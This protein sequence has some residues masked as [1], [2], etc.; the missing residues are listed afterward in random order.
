MVL[1]EIRRIARCMLLAGSLLALASPAFA[2]RDLKN[3]PDPDPEEER[4]TFIVAD[5]FEVNLYA[6][7]PLLAKPIQMNFDAQGRLWIASSEVYPQV[8]PGQ[9]ATDKILVLE[10]KNGDGKA[11][12]TTVFADGLLIPTG[13]IPDDNGGAYV[14][15]STELLHLQDRDADLKADES[16]IAL[17]GFGT[18][19]THHLL[20]TLRWGPDG[21]LYMN[22]SIYIHSH[23]ETPY[24]V[25][26]LN[27]G[28]IW[29]FRPETLELDVFCEGFV[30]SWG[31]HQD[32]WG[33]SFATDG[34]Y[35]E[36]INYVFPGSVFVAAPGAK[37]RVEGLNPGSPKHCGLE[38]VSGRHLPDDWQGSMITNDFRA[39]RV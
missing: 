13:V 36:G 24:G 32:R 29:R 33:Q 10:D 23:V 17:S 1:I 35:G 15:N 31:H 27:G 20:H 38:I 34:A 3:I 14:V 30:N 5:G 9:K 11:D 28:G 21:C 6:A 7:D 18:E 16:R 37:R 22:Q 19:D 12:K 39:H 8:K 26:R 4:K 25:K 2:Q